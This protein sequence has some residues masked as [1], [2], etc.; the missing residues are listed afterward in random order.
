MK[1]HA[2]LKVLFFASYFPKPDNPLMGTWALSEAQALIRQNVDVLTVSCTSWVPNFLAITPGSQSYSNCP[3]EFTWPG[4]V[5]VLYPRWAY[6]PVNP[7]KA[8]TYR[9]PQPYLYLAWKSV[10]RKLLSI[11]T[12]FNPDLIFCHHL[13]PNTWI[14][15]QLPENFQQPIIS[16][17]HDFDEI[18]DCNHLPQRRLAI[19]TAI[20]RCKLSLAVSDR[21]A[22]DMRQLFPGHSVYTYHHGV[23]LPSR[24]LLS[25][26]RPLA[27]QGKK[28]VLSCALFS[29]RKSIPL[30]IES[31]CRIAHR[32]PNAVLRI[33]GGGPDE[34]NI[35]QTIEQYD[36]KNQVTL[37]GKQP[38]NYVLQEMV[39]SDCFALPSWNEPLGQVYLEAM[40]AGK[41]IICCRDS[42]INDIITHKL[43]GYS[44]PPNNTDQVSEAL[45]Q[46]LRND[47]DRLKMGNN[48]LK[49]VKETLTWD[50]RAIKLIE[51]FNIALN[52]DL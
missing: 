46:M 27:L 39:W 15:S 9:N 2:H 12:S 49:L 52:S 26:P 29:K 17:D 31:F 4:H 36:R 33:I 32:H 3:Q 44:V 14:I 43:H 22:D 10:K 13:L 35:L 18:T 38:H 16:S 24:D 28:I 37:L 30:L 41:P 8:W 42:G 23:D 34:Y 40:A 47:F 6:Y 11:I 48:A 19:T 45:D 51:L 50:S 5:R 7:V 20:K 25:H 21:M 1:P